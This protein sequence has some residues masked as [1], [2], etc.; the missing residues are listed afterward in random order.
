MNPDTVT[1]LNTNRARRRLTSLIEANALTNEKFRMDRGL[2][3]SPL[4]LPP[5][6]SCLI[7]ARYS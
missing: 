6:A 5:L 3:L 1:R 4:A 7:Y 2:L